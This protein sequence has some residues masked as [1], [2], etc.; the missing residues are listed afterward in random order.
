MSH[1]GMI[2]IHFIQFIA[3]FCCKKLIINLLIISFLFEVH[4]TFISIFYRFHHFLV[5][6]IR[7]LKAHL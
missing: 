1:K 4:R 7:F 5:F 2:I 3:K 6:L